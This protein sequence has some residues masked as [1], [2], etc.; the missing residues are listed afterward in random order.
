MHF[1]SRVL[2]RLRS[3][4]RKVLRSFS[5]T[6]QTYDEAEERARE[7]L[8]RML[9]PSQRGDFHRHGCFAVQV[10]GRGKFWILPR[11]FFNVL[12]METG[13]SY[14]AVPGSVVPLSDLML[15][16]KLVLENDPASYFA[17]AN[18]RCELIPVGAAQQQ[19]QVATA[20]HRL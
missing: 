5:E 4:P 19:R 12:H 15:A 18:C 16:Q 2:A 1:C 20:M 13:Y 9:T 8:L 7:L 14:C 10:E 3:L 6:G 17:V 11:P